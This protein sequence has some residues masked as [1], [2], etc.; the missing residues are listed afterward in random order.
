[1]AK[2]Q[3]LGVG[4]YLQQLELLEEDSDVADEEAEV[5]PSRFALIL[6][7]KW[8]WGRLSAPEVQELAAAAH[9]DGLQHPEVHKLA[10]IGNWGRFPG[11]AHRDLLFHLGKNSTSMFG[12][13]SG[14][15]LPLPPHA[16]GIS[17]AVRLASSS[18]EPVRRRMTKKGPEKVVGKKGSEK[19]VHKKSKKKRKYKQTRGCVYSRAY[20]NTYKATS[21]RAEAQ[22]AGQVALQEAFGPKA[23]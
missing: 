19:V 5:V 2:R 1:M 15:P 20:H 22:R 21:S 9:R 23:S 17:S 12:A 18:Q 14:E 16:R 4:G 3:K 6:T 7:Q 8:G 13:N 11:N 10:S